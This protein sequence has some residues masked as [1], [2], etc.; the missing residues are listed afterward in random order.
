ME[1]P[2]TIIQDDYISQ[3]VLLSG[4]AIYNFYVKVLV[5]S[6]NIDIT[7]TELVANIHKLSGIA[8]GLVY[9]HTTLCDYAK[10][11]TVK[12]AIKTLNGIQAYFKEQQ[13]EGMKEEAQQSCMDTLIDYLQHTAKDEQLDLFKL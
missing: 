12:A 9:S 10:L 7:D 11:E 5:V 1:Q 13:G 3:A 4:Q 6:E 2:Q 8:K